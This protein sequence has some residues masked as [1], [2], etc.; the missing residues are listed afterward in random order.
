MRDTLQQGTPTQATHLQPPLHQPSNAVRPTVDTRTSSTARDRGNKIRFRIGKS[1]GNSPDGAQ[2]YVNSPGSGP[3]QRHGLTQGL[4]WHPHLDDTRA[5]DRRCVARD[6]CRTFAD[7][8]PLRGR[9]T[10]DR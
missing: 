10:L 5:S 9:Y 6:T 8:T 4:E 1:C 7:D 2:S 3:S